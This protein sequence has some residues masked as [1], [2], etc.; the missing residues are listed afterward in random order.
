MR[1]T[2]VTW[3]ETRHGWCFC[4]YSYSENEHGDDDLTERDTIEFT[5]APRLAGPYFGAFGI[6]E[7][8]RRG[9]AP[10]SG[11]ALVEAALARVDTPVGKA[12][13]G[14]MANLK[15]GCH[16]KRVDIDIVGGNIRRPPRSVEHGLLTWGLRNLL[17]II[18]AQY[19]GVF[20]AATM[21]DPSSA[22]D[23]FTEIKSVYDALA[24]VQA[25]DD[26]KKMLRGV[27][28]DALAAMD[29]A[30][31][32]EVLLR[33]AGQW[34]PHKE[35]EK[36]GGDDAEGA[37]SRSKA[38][39]TS[40]PNRRET[41]SPPSESDREKPRTGSTRPEPEDDGEV[42]EDERRPRPKRSRG[43]DEEADTRGNGRDRRKPARK[44]ERE[45]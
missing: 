41:D 13:A 6:Y 38:G 39:T 7:W 40:G 19:V 8:I 11:A 42:D 31:V 45:R 37:R 23:L 34:H 44:P 24:K 15:P 18:A 5:N 20:D 9:R 27:M 26:R 36:V 17:Q 3:T 2:V 32:A 43:A 22:G 25:P 30:L 14:L 4:G 12:L 35:H 29:Y 10:V 33:D 21:P 28:L 1:E 16:D